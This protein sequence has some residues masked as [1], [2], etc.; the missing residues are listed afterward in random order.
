MVIYIDEGH[1]VALEDTVKVGGEDI[2]YGSVLGNHHKSKVA[3]VPVG[4]GLQEDRLPVVK[5]LFHDAIYMVNRFQ[6]RRCRR[7]PL[8]WYGWRGCGRPPNHLQ[9]LT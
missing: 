9:R 7:W 4:L 2:P 3:V 5:K 8:R 6:V 1:R